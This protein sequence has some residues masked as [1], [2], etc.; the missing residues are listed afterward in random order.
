LISNFSFSVFRYQFCWLKDG[1]KTSMFCEISHITSWKNI[2]PD[3]YSKNEKI[4]DYDILVILKG[5][6]LQEYSILFHK[7]DF[8]TL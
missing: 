5:I 4:L 6:D 3:L 8:K 1:E 7:M 2:F